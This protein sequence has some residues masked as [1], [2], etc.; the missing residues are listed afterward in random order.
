MSMLFIDRESP[1]FAQPLLVGRP[2]IGSRAEI[3]RHLDEILD[4]RWLSNE[5][6]VVL[7]LERRLAS[8]I[9]VKHCLTVCNATIGLEI[10]YRVTEL[11]GEVI[12]PANT[13]AATVHALQWQGIKPVFCD[14]DPKTHNLDVDSVEA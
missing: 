9:G 14:I 3:H 10:A 7:E 8:Y 5:G 12:V 6:Q 2:N 13:F 11:S 4:R 1:L